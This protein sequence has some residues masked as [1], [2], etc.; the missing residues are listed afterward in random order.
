M[1]SNPCPMLTKGLRDLALLVGCSVALQASPAQDG[2]AIVPVYETVDIKPDQSGAD[3]E[4]IKVGYDELTATNVTLQTLIRSAYDVGINQITGGPLWLKSEKYDI[5]AKVD[6]SVVDELKNL[7]V[8][9]DTRVLAR[10]MLQVLLANHFRLTVQRETK[11]VPVYELVIAED[12]LKLQESIPRAYYPH[13]RVIRVGRG[14][15]TGREV[16]VATLASLLSEELS[17]TVLDK[18]A[19]TDHYDIALEWPTRGGRQPG[20]ENRLS[21]GSPE[22]SIFAAIQEQLGLKLEPQKV[23]MEFLVIDHIERPSEN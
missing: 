16:P 1:L 3:S 9:P 11:F 20:A 22:P 8:G 14:Q 13:G 2:A 17:C 7:S 18:T 6:Q 10:P 15:I 19:L 4:G 23:P 21:P 5:E 12:G